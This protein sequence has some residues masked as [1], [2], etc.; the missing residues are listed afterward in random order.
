MGASSAIFKKNML[1]M[2]C[3]ST[4][5]SEFR[6]KGCWYQDDELKTTMNI[7]NRLVDL[8]LNL[9]WAGKG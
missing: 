4:S 7:S 1:G 6:V 2:C 3:I 9:I 8:G 5:G